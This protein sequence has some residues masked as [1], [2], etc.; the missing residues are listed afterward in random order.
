M[1]PQRENSRRNGG[2]S[3]FVSTQTA[4]RKPFFRHERWARLL[5]ST[6]EHYSKASFVLH[7]YVIMPDHLHFLVTPGE[8]L[9][10]TVQLIKGGF[11]FRAKRELE[12]KFDIWQPG[13]SDHRVRDE[14]DWNRH[15]NYIRQNPLDAKLVDHS[16]LYEFMGFPDCEFP[17]GLKPPTDFDTDVRAEARTLHQLKGS[18]GTSQFRFPNSNGTGNHAT[19]K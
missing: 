17:R 5:T 18:K 19:Q 16:A 10:K 2:C 6:L 15:L 8:S 4:G 1:R 7:A 14:E 9:E 11:S 13:F 12:W 3:Y